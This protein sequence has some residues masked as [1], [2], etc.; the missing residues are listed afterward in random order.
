MQDTYYGYASC[1]EQTSI[2]YITVLLILLIGIVLISFGSL[3]KAE[4]Q[5]QGRNSGAWFV[6]GCIFTFNAFIA[7][8]VSKLAYNEAHIVPFIIRQ[9]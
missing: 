3:A 8:K 9:Y 7:L 4:A 6:L 5:R 1:T 2:S